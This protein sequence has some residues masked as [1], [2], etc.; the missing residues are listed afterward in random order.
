ML[1]GDY[2]GW[3]DRGRVFQMTKDSGFGWVRQQ[4]R[5]MDLHD[6]SGAIYWDELDRI[7]DDADRRWGE[8]AAERCRRPSWA[9]DN[10]RNGLPNRANISATST[11]S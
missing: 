8:A 1:Y 9:T 5:W 10:G 2:S 6:R 7:V 3:Q 4:V 11:T